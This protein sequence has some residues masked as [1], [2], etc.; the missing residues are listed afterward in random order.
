MTTIIK[1]IRL[2]NLRNDEH[3]GFHYE[4]KRILEK[5]MPEA[6]DI[7]PAMATAYYVAVED[8][9]KSYKIVQKS[10]YTELIADADAV[11]D[12][13]ITGIQKVLGAAQ[14][15]FDP[16][17]VKAAKRVKISMD[18]F[19]DI[20]V[21]GYTAEM[22]DI[23]NLMQM[24]RGDLSADVTLLGLDRWV[25]KLEADHA[26]FSRLFNE[27]QD[28]QAEKDSLN[29]L[30]TCRKT[31]DAAYQAIKN[32]INAGIEFNGEDKYRAFVGDLNASIDYYNNVMAQRKGRNA[33]KKDESPALSF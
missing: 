24:F 6:V 3:L 11:C 18:A 25:D 29:R 14:S 32:R 9:D 23:T 33:A 31:T 13:D 10:S 22:T 26:T 28:E 16:E 20:R 30:R 8:Q 12:G 5:Y 2:P 17:V 15:D 1:G 4:V 19:G 27:R 7:P 21:K